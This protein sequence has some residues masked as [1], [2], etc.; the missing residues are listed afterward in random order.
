MAYKILKP[1]ES[2][3]YLKRYETQ[4]K[5]R[6]GQN[7][8]I[9]NNVVEKIAR[10]GGASNQVVLEI[11]PGL[12]ALTQYLLRDAR[13]VVAV[14]IDQDC[15]AILKER[16]HQEAK[17]TLIHHDFLTLHPSELEPYPITHL[18]AN[19]P[20]YITTPILFHVIE[21]YPHIH[22]ISIMV[23]KEVAD[24]F[25]ALPKTKAYG[26]LS[27]ILQTQFEMRLEMQV[28]AKVFHPAPKVSSSV[29]SLKRKEDHRLPSVF[30]R[31]VKMGF[32]HRR[33][34]LLNNLKGMTGLP[35]VLMRLKHDPSVRA[36][37]LSPSQWVELFHELQKETSE[38]LE[39]L[40][41]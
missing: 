24:R 14:E 5:K 6:F 18:I 27:I 37:A 4:A 25:N 10:V 33:K 17:F 38:S 41:K 26:A 12:G 31:L 28:P 21:Q 16:F 3:A 23:Q 9:D 29:I 11:G 30:F 36:E 20:Y 19:L 34:T 8:I 7:F 15:V 32:A 22:H 40:I 1:S 13:H 35:D 2:L 39:S